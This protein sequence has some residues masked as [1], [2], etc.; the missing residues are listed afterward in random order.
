MTT[1]SKCSET[2]LEGIG[3]VGLDV[4]GSV[5]CTCARVIVAWGSS[6]N[7]R[8]PSFPAS[9]SQMID[10]VYSCTR[11]FNSLQR[12]FYIIC[13]I[14]KNCFPI[15]VQNV[16]FDTKRYILS[17]RKPLA[18]VKTKNSLWIRE[19]L[20]RGVQSRCCHNLKVLY[21]LLQTI[22]FAKVNKIKTQNYLRVRIISISQFQNV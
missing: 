20:H 6:L 12:G 21:S 17:N 5:L 8:H 10:R 4:L 9:L 1:T 15:C 13:T 7:D 22:F 19:T 2:I 18:Y 3:P 16:V 11:Y 14:A